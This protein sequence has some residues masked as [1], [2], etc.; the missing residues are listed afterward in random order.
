MISPRSLSC[1]VLLPL[2][3]CFPL[4]DREEPVAAMSGVGGEMSWANLPGGHRAPL[5][6][7][8]SRWLRAPHPHGLL[9]TAKEL[10][11]SGRQRAG[12][13]FRFGRQDDGS[14]ATGFLPADGEK[15]HG[16]LGTLAE[17][18]SSY[19]RKKGGFSFRFGRR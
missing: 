11:M 10:Q 13:R 7:G 16:P 9:V 5:P 1:L 18:L 3:A 15:A 17:E 12:F 19:S 8:S 2:G 4:L 14:E 6:R